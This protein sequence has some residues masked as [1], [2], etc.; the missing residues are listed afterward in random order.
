MA[1]RK[2][3]CIQYFNKLAWNSF[4]KQRCGVGLIWSAKCL[5]CQVTIITSWRVQSFYGAGLF[6]MVFVPPWIAL[7]VVSLLTQ[8]SSMDANILLVIFLVENIFTPF[9]LNSQERLLWNY[10]LAFL[11]DPSGNLIAFTI[12]RNLLCSKNVSIQAEN[13]TLKLSVTVHILLDSGFLDKNN[14]T[15]LPDVLSIW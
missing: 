12:W 15:I 5:G 10:Y 13:N 8:C 7:H 1:S 14:V 2:L 11:S 6:L 4:W 9:P 3:C